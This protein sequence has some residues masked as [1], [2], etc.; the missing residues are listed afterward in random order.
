MR[1]YVETLLFK[2]V[3]AN[4]KIRNFKIAEA[5]YF[6]S[7][8][9]GSSAG[10]RQSVGSTRIYREAETNSKQLLSLPREMFTPNSIHQVLP[11]PSLVLTPNTNA[12][13]PFRR[14]QIQTPRSLHQVLSRPSLVFTPN[15]KIHPPGSASA[16]RGFHSKL[17]NPNSIRQ[18]LPW[19]SLVF[20]PNSKIHLPGSISA[21]PGFHSKF[22]NPK[23]KLLM[24]PQRDSNSCSKLEKLT[25]DFR[26]RE[27]ESVLH[28]FSGPHA[29]E[30]R[31]MSV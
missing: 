20:T 17:Q 31:V 3:T 5:D 30:R 18:V 8:S 26:T 12:Y 15:S 16:I 1:R 13:T 25:R 22:Q 27:S 14:F 10:K 7:M 19:P 6:T 4:S 21:F 11:R 28:L 2:K 9:K 29:H 24:C 23:S